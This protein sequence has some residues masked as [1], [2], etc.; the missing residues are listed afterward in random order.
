MKQNFTQF[1]TLGFSQMSRK[2]SEHLLSGSKAGN[3][4]QS[5]VCSQKKVIVKAKTNIITLVKMLLVLCLTGMSFKPV[6][7][8]TG[9][10]GDDEPHRARRIWL[11]E[12]RSGGG[13]RQR[14]RIDGKH[15][16]AP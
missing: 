16:R 15:S 13:D 12:R 1:L 8:A 9:R 10:I 11:C 14:E 5:N 2:N 4:N 3:C 7:A 6:F